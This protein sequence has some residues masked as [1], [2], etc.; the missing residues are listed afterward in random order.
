MGSI[1]LTGGNSKGATA[2]LEAGVDVDVD[3]DVD[4]MRGTGRSTLELGHLTGSGGNMVCAT[5]DSCL[6]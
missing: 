1:Q 4:A 6:R 5:L 2:A 3:V